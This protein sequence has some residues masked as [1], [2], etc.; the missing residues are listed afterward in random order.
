MVQSLNPDSVWNI[1]PNRD[2]LATKI[3]SYSPFLSFYL[4]TID[5][6]NILK[7]T[8]S[9]KKGTKL[10]KRH[11]SILLPFLLIFLSEGL[12]ALTEKDFKHSMNFY[13]RLVEKN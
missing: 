5:N 6:Y 13:Q 11:I 10:V 4:T 12:S 9:E 7:I 2:Y 1:I 8:S 3:Y